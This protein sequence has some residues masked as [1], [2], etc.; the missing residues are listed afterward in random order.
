M[1]DQYTLIR[2]IETFT[3]R[4]WTAL[5][6]RVYDG[7]V[8]RF[9]NGYTGRANSINPIYYSSQDIHT[10]IR[11]C[12]DLY[13]A[14]RQPSLFRLTNAM[15]PADLD[16][17]LLDKGYQTRSTTHV[18]IVDL[19]KIIPV[20]HPAAEHTSM[21]T[22]TWLVDFVRLNKVDSR[23]MNTMRQMLC[24]IQPNTCFMRLR[25][26][27][28]TAAAGLGVCEN[29]HLGFF[30]IVTHPDFRGQGWGTALMNSLFAWGKRQGATRGYLQVVAEND[31]AQKLY[32]KLG[33]RKAYEYW[34]R[35]KFAEM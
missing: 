3:Y 2:E 24:R 14:R 27:Q 15:V 26:H 18:M 4:A 20:Y 8:L 34:Y 10:K 16:N 35:E 19:R 1:S 6:T 33:F 13:F 17:I 9:A 32:R 28:E 21:L 29:D 25:H 5:E 12:E 11:V 30:D 7:W 31:L 22:E 23:H